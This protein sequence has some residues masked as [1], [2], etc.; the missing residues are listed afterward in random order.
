M[1]LSI[2]LT[3]YTWPVVPRCSAGTCATSPLRS[4]KPASTLDVVLD[5]VDPSASIAA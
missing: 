4:M 2:S 1:K 5:A 3:N